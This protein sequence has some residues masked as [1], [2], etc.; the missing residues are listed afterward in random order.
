MVAVSDM[1]ELDDDFEDA[2][3]ADEDEVEDDGADEVGFREHSEP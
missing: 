2:E 3:Y 1:D